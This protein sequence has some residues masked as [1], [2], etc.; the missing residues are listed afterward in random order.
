MEKKQKKQKTQ[1]NSVCIPEIQNL[2]KITFENCLCADIETIIFEYSSFTCIQPETLF[3][4]HIESSIYLICSL[5]TVVAHTILLNGNSMNDDQ[6]NDQEHE[7]DKYIISSSCIPAILIGNQIF[8]GTSD[9]DLFFGEYSVL[10]QKEMSLGKD[11]E[12]EQI[13]SELV[14]SLKSRLF[15]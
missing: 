12:N 2:I 14:T 6:E 4:F 9:L 15:N 13:S 11:K 7:H 8:T 1:L 10:P 5:Q 3:Q